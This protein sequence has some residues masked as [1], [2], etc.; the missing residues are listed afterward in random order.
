[1][2]ISRR[3]LIGGLISFVAVPAIVRAANLMPVRGFVLDDLQWE[4]CTSHRQSTL[5]IRL[6]SIS[7]R[8]LNPNDLY[9]TNNEILQ[10][11]RYA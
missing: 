3:G 1:M 7:W 4:T 2:A 6:P 10:D 5:R 8:L 9:I 11:L